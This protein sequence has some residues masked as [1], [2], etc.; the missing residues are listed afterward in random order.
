MRA[1]LVGFSGAG[2]SSISRALAEKFGLRTIDTDELVRRRTGQ[3]IAQLIRVEG[4]QNFRRLEEDAV[5][6]AVAMDV[7]IIATGGGVL[8]SSRNQERLL[9]F[10]PLVYLYAPL[11]VLLQRLKMDA[12]G[13]ERPLLEGDG[14]RAASLFVERQPRYRLASIVVHTQWA[15]IDEI[16]RRIYRE[17]EMSASLTV[18][19][20]ALA[21]TQSTIV[22]GPGGRSSLGKR[23]RALTPR[24][25]RAA[26]ITDDRVGAHWRAPISD[27]LSSS[28]FDVLPLTVGAGESAKS[29]QQVGALCE[30]LLVGGF[31]RGDVVVALGGGVVGDLAGLVASLYMRGV[32][33]VQVATSLVA[34]VDAAIGGK[35]GV[36]LDSTR[37]SAKNVIGSF[38][39]ASIV[40]S[41]QEML[42]TLDD[43]AFREGMAE[44][45]K[46]GFIESNEFLLWL[47]QHAEKILSRDP[48]LVREVVEFCSE[49]KLRFVTG[50]VHD[51][52]GRRVLLNFGHTIGHVI[53]RLTSYGEFLHGEAVA[54]GMAEAARIGEARGVSEAGTV[55]TVERVLR[56]FGLP[57]ELPGHLAVGLE[58]PSGDGSPSDAGIGAEEWK[59]TLTADKKRVANEID[60]VL[61]ERPGSAR[62]ESIAVDE[63]VSA[64]PRVVV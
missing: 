25:A 5:A 58:R 6:E 33:L 20:T 50:D 4:E 63:L 10:G 11:D 15:T 24:A 26:V 21:G 53:E 3:T 59:R 7:D 23:L 22:I 56:K 35:T 46:Y 48:Q 55:A 2:K 51:R 17:L 30:E 57:T 64:L 40:L 38:Y 44:A 13:E 16:A 32:H 12:G 28:G 54:I 37:I 31:G 62:V 29:L 14:E 34:Q 49:A 1:V 39:P 47:E 41:D 45:V 18:I 43:R 60:F 8:E 61:L 52:K 42:G 19:E 27:D 36:N 9:S